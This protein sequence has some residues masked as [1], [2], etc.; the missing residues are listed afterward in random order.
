MV[1][2]K[3]EKEKRQPT[4]NV[5]LNRRSQDYHRLLFHLTNIWWEALFCDILSRY[6]LGKVYANIKCT[7]ESLHKDPT[8]LN[9]S[10][11]HLRRSLHLYSN[12]NSKITITSNYF[13]TVF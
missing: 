6:S 10:Y 1:I 12:G 11:N 13:I 3:T 4:L 5:S 7:R 8:T 2:K 9:G